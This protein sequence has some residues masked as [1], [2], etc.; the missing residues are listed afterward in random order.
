MPLTPA[1]VD[2]RPTKSVH[3]GAIFAEEIRRKEPRSPEAQ[4]FLLEGLHLD[5]IR[6]V[7]V[8][9]FCSYAQVCSDVGISACDWMARRA[10]VFH[11][12]ESTIVVTPP[13]PVAKPV[14]RVP[15]AKWATR[16]NGEVPPPVP[17]ARRRI[18]T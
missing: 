10:R 15:S 5:P 17:F 1:A 7:F 4:R 3:D 6:P 14:R 16:E 8:T 13:F 11:E 9:P 18:Q 2:P 12:R